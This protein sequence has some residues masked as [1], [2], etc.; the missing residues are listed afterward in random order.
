MEDAM[1][2]YVRWIGIVAFWMS[3]F[4]GCSE[5]EDGS[6]P[7]KSTVTVAA[8]AITPADVKVLGALVYGETSPSVLYRRPP[9]YQAFSFTGAP[10]DDVDIWVRSTDGDA[11]VWLI[12]PQFQVLAQ[13]DDADLGTRDAHVRHVLDSASG[14]GTYL[15]VFREYSQLTSHVTVALQAA[16]CE[17]L[18]CVDV[19]AEC[20]PVDD[21]C[22]GQLDCGTCAGGETCGSGGV[23]NVCPDVACTQESGFKAKF[24]QAFN[25]AS[26]TLI[27]TDGTVHQGLGRIDVAAGW[28]GGELML[29]GTTARAAEVRLIQAG[30]TQV[31]ASKAGDHLVG[32]AHAAW[33]QNNWGGNRVEQIVMRQFAD[34]DLTYPQWVGYLRLLT[35]QAER[36]VPVADLADFRVAASRFMTAIEAGTLQFQIGTPWGIDF[37]STPQTVNGKT[38]AFRYSTSLGMPPEIG[39]QRTGVWG[40]NWESYNPEPKCNGCVERVLGQ[41]TLRYCDGPVSR[42]AAASVCSHLGGTLATIRDVYT[43]GAIRALD[44]GAGH[45]FIGLSDAV[46]EG[47]YTWDSGQPFD[48]TSW[49]PGEPADPSGSKDCV[50][51][52]DYAG[53]MTRWSAQACAATQPFVC[54]R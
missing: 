52:T 17:R 20:G 1:H 24:G 36:Q 21:G 18:T 29:I 28:R 32:I 38:F 22:G 46:T 23:P 47:Q 12:G 19:G 6:L 27:A 30:G 41:R 42:T 50:Q 16:Q 3:A 10:G 25:P 54:E 39:F 33:K 5:S 15:I 7:Q 13:N 48:A 37:P 14:A 44:P 43:G 40:P 51:L 26:F 4:V 49:A 9:R 34:P 53:R 35:Q 8:D 31:L 45:A 2:T 11:M